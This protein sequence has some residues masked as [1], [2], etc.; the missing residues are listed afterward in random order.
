[1]LICLLS[2]RK[3]PTCRRLV[4]QRFSSSSNAKVKCRR[5]ASTTWSRRPE[6]ALQTQHAERG[7][8]RA[9]H[10][11]RSVWPLA[12]SVGSVQLR[13]YRRVYFA[14]KAKV[15]PGRPDY[16][17]QN[18]ESNQC[19]SVPSALLSHIMDRGEMRPRR[20]KIHAKT[21]RGGRFRFR[22]RDVGRFGQRQ[23]YR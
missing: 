8:A 9:L 3:A 11:F 13:T 16:E 6:V 1:M 21:N 23:S 15:R 22:T 18:N 10:R 17:P 20:E 4:R 12:C 14:R 2:P 19:T 7:Q 5:N